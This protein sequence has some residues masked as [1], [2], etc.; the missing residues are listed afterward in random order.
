MR[1][2]LAEPGDLPVMVDLARDF[3]ERTGDGAGLPFDP[4]VAE[5]W[6]GH[7][8]KQALALIAETEEGE[9]AGALPLM[10]EAPRYSSTKALWDIGF[11]VK[12]E[13]RK[14]KAAMMLLDAAKAIRED[15][16]VPLFVGVSSGFEI[17]RQDKFFSRAG[18]ER[19][20]ALYLMR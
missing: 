8:I 7:S 18:F 4:Q 5:G 11:Y 13:H 16:A 17:S 15:M 3:Y 14:S 20:G 2:R 12:P 1:V 19:A 9:I 10:F 6:A